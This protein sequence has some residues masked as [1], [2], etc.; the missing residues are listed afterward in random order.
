MRIGWVRVSSACLVALLALLAVVAG[1]CLGGDRAYG[2]P[3]LE[4]IPAGKSIRIVISGGLV[5]IFHV[6]RPDGVT[7]PAPLVV[8]LHGGYGDGATGRA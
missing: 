6:Y 8:M 1:G 3:D 4:A 7:G 2:A 5:R